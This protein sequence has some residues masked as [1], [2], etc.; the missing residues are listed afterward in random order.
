MR[1]RSTALY[2]GLVAAT[3]VVTL[4]ACDTDPGR[5]SAVPADA[6][7]ATTG[8]EDG[9]A[10]PTVALTTN[11]RGRGVPVD[12]LV[13]VS[14]EG[15][16]LEAVTVRSAAGVLPGD[17]SP[18]ARTW[19]ARE[20]LEPGTAY[21]VRATA[22]GGSG[23]GSAL[24]RRFTTEDLPLSR[25]TFASVAPL[26]GQTV[27]VGMPVVVH[28]D[29]PVRDRAAME[30][31]MHVTAAPEQ[32]GAWHWLSDTEAHWRPRRY[33]EAGTTVEVDLDVN[34]VAAGNGVYGQ[35]DR[36]IRF[37]VGAAHVYRV[38]ARTHQM[39]VYEN[40]TLLRTLPITTGKAGFTTRSGV[41][42]IMEKFPSRRMR[43]ETVGIGAGDP[44]FYDID[45]VRW[46]M[47]LTYS[48]EFIHA[49]PWSVGSQGYANV[50][51]GCTGMSAADAE[52][53]YQLTRIGDVVE[54]TGTDRPME[55]ENGYGDWNVPFEQYRAGSALA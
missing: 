36:R 6:A 9:D 26:D 18:D 37:S 38:N 53:L 16:A 44:E 34:G 27:G 30:Q 1:M 10:G 52:W 41:K 22:A 5:D 50:S 40:G 8:G 33:W 2:R 31:H 29:V 39:K 51:H 19:T 13:T 48:G 24:R 17:L 4:A 43:S 47:R 28:F 12:T 55:L 21:T 25:Q 3:L 54:Y 7:A 14:A 35:E 42:V 11:A 46:A 32:V 20:R 15:G 49:A 23:D 45:D